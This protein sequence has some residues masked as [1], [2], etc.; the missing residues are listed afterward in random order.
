MPHDNNE[1][2]NSTVDRYCAY[3]IDRGR[4][5]LLDPLT[6]RCPTCILHSNG[7]TKDAAVGYINDRIS[8]LR[9]IQGVL[10]G[11]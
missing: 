2:A 11:S 9:Y 8:S 5:E 3:C 7:L 10:K 4:L 1:Q 6:H